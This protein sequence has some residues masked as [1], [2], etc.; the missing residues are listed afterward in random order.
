MTRSRY[1]TEPFTAGSF[2]PGYDGETQLPQE[3]TNLYGSGGLYSTPTEMAALARMLLNQGV[4][5][6]RQLLSASSITEMARNQTTTQA[7]QPVLMADAYGLGWD[8]VRQDGLAV[9]GVTAWHKNGGTFIYGSDFFVLPDEGL[10]LMIT[11]TSTTY[12]PGMLAERILLQALVERGSLAAPPMRLTATSVPAVT[13]GEARAAPLAGVYA[14]TDDIYR[15]Q[16]QVDRTV[17]MA[18]YADGI[19]SDEAVVMKMRDDGFFASDAEPLVSYRTVLVHGQHYLTRRAPAGLGHYLREVPYLQRLEAKS[20]VSAAWQNRLGR[21]WLVVNEPES[22]WLPN[23]RPVLTLSDVPDLPGYIVINADVNGKQNQ[24]A[25]A[26]TSD[27]IALMCLK[28][29]VAFGRDLNDVVIVPR[30]GEEWVIVGSGVFRPASSV[31]PLGA[32]GAVMPI[33]TE[34]YAQWLSVAASAT[35][36]IIALSGATAWK[37]YDSEFNLQSSGEG[38]SPPQLPAHERPAYLLIYGNPNAVIRASLT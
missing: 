2:A 6:G 23:G 4:F 36:Q 15:L 17:V 21:R 37:L 29:P 19:W 35:A 22:S 32:S 25:D 11:G 31:T 27:H 5:D 33:G 7:L 12:R 26:S 16:T 14:A 1:A 3:F 20:P 8:G 24:I 28:I 30:S 9:V 10:A 38:S 34:G 13:A 18:N